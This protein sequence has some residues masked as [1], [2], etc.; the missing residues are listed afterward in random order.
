LPVE[1]DEDSFLDMLRKVI[2]GVKALFVKY[3]TRV[4][5][6]CL[7]VCCGVLLFAFFH[8]RSWFESYNPFEGRSGK[9]GRNV[10]KNMKRMSKGAR[11]GKK[12]HFI[13]YDAADRADITS[14]S[15]NGKPISAPMVGE[16]FAPG[17]WVIFRKDE[18]GEVVKD[19]FTVESDS[20][21]LGAALKCAYC[22]GFGH[23][24]EAC[25]MLPKEK[26]EEPTEKIALT[27]AQKKKPLP[28][29]P[30]KE[31]SKQDW[32][33]TQAC[34]QC[35]Q[36][37]HLKHQCGGKKLPSSPKKA[38]ALV[39]GSAKID[40]KP[41][42]N[43]MGV[44]LK[45]SDYVAQVVVS[46]IGILVNAHVYEQCTHFK[47]GDK[48]V[49]KTKVVLREVSGNRDLFLCLKFDG[50]PNGLPKARFTTPEVNQKCWF[51]AREGLM[52]EGMVTWLGDGADG[53]EMRTTCSTEPGDCGGVY[54][55]SN[56]RVI[57][58]HFAAGRPKFDNR[59]VP[60][61]DGMLQWV[62]KN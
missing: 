23:A 6:F 37:G 44:A 34:H 50:C 20:G 57:G 17:R 31:M 61:T 7:A 27:V 10:N 52:S 47:F 16:P 58:V 5:Y 2:P 39:A 3:R 15:L 55:N 14:C 1:E 59:A 54:V 35:G 22:G 18:D 13:L 12:K 62:P 43:N 32:I 45:G 26:V 11:K 19:D 29:P 51:F 41:F 40:P 53:F 30:K 8:H 21:L 49:E 42:R 24:S 28:V 46:W 25:P 33:K 36:L 4:A 38:E 9:K 56:G 48:V 60:V